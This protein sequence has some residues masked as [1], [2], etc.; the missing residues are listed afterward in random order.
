MLQIGAV[1]IYPGLQESEIGNR[2]MY[3]LSIVPILAHTT[4]TSHL[5]TQYSSQMAEPLAWSFLTFG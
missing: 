5:L 2:L 4:L 3:N 1:V